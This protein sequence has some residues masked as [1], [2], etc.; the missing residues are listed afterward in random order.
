[1]ED[2]DIPIPFLGDNDISN[3]T[4]P[5]N[6]ASWVRPE[7]RGPLLLALSLYGQPREVMGKER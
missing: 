2:E 6:I 1:M 3:D 4:G 7:D 5:N